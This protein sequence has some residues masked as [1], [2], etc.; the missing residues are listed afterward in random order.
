MSNVKGATAMRVSVGNQAARRYLVFGLA[1]IGAAAVAL[2]AAGS[3]RAGA[4]VVAQCEAGTNPGL[5]ATGYGKANNNQYGLLENCGNPSGDP[6]SALGVKVLTQSPT[7]N[8]GRHH[9]RA[10]SATTFI[11]VRA[12]A[13]LRRDVGHK[14]RLMAGSATFGLGGSGST[15]WTTYNWSGAG[16][17]EFSARLVCE[18]SPNCNNSSQAKTQVRD[19][20]ITVR[21]STPPTVSAGGELVAGGWLRGVQGLTVQGLDVGGGLRQLR[22]TANGQVVGSAVYPC[23]LIA[24]SLVTRF[25]PCEGSQE[26]QVAGIGTASAPFHNGNN[27]VQVCAWDLG[28]VESPNSSCRTYTVKVDNLQPEGGFRSSLDP[29]DPELIR[30][31]V[32][33]GHSG[34]VAGQI[35][36]RPVGSGGW[37][38]L[39]TQLVGGELRAGIDSVGLPSGNYE[40][41]LEVADAAG[42]EAVSKLREDGSPMV[43]AFP[44]K[45]ATELSAALPGGSGTQAVPYKQ[46]SKVF[47]HLLTAAGQPIAGA[48]VRVTERFDSGSLIDKRVRVVRTNADGRY[49]SALP[50]GPSRRIDVAY[51]G[52]KRYAAGERSGLDLDVESKAR[53]RTSKRKVKAGKRVRFRGSVRRDFAA[54]PAGGKLIEL[55]VKEGAGRWGTIREAFP[56]RAT[57]HYKLRHRFKRFY[58]EPTTF[59]FRVKVTKE[60]GWPYTAPVRSRARKVTIVPR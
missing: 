7:G 31:P 51:A 4:Y 44:L 41:K 49:G 29:N 9:W 59:K 28:T 17:T 48:D 1:V 18:K 39:P 20:R 10:P 58:L 2:I 38:G 23:S 24:S 3:A 21:D 45:T 54:I 15:P 32:S 57:G 5:D 34:V 42:N 19:V 56:T 13:R 33:D 8:S 36:Y 6:P 30:A 60:Q 46:A 26:L 25:M 43:L 11:A 37:I 22:A 14:A 12:V 16:V 53:F 52:S 27:T 35:H 55:Q 50:G 47:G 40:F